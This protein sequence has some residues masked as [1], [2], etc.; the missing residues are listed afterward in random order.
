MSCASDR[1][2]KRSLAKE[3]QR[4]RS[5]MEKT[6]NDNKIEVLQQ[7]DR[8]TYVSTKAKRSYSSFLVYFCDG[9]VDISPPSFG[10]DMTRVPTHF[11]VDFP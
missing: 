6:L 8:P 2:W 1:E 10:L 11:D 9:E 7:E 4:K 3:G 5:N